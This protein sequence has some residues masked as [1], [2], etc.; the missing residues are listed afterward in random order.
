ML[1]VAEEDIE[2]LEIVADESEYGESEDDEDTTASY[3]TT[4]T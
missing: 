4:K 2:E 1:D 3:V